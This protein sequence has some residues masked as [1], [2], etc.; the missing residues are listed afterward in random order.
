MGYTVTPWKITI[1]KTSSSPLKI[2]K[3]PKGNHRIPTIFR[4]ELLVFREGN[5]E[6][7]VMEVWEDDVPVKLGVE[8]LL[9][10]QSAGVF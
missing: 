2:G 10:I 1:P 9:G 8:L 7:K 6:P 4:C 5:M 3:L